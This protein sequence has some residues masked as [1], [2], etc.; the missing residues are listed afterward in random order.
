MSKQQV[1]AVATDNASNMSLAVQKLSEDSITVVDELE[2]VT[3]PN[4]L[5]LELRLLRSI[6]K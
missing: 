2:S 6:W 1:L 4:S 3:H 5:F